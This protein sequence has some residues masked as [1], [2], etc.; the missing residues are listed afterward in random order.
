MDQADP[1]LEQVL[2]FHLVADVILL[3]YRFL[4]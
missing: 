3:Q 4:R 1:L 2:G